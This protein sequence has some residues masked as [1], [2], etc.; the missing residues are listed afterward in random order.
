MF[1]CFVSTRRRR[2]PME[3]SAARMPVWIGIVVPSFVRQSDYAR[4]MTEQ[5]GATETRVKHVNYTVL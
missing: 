3:S 5:E 4:D 2:H 1:A